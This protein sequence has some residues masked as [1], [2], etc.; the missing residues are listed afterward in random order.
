MKDKNH[1]KWNKERDGT[2]MSKLRRNFYFNAT[3]Y[4]FVLGF[5]M[6]LQH[7]PY[8]ISSI[9]KLNQTNMH[10][11]LVDYPCRTKRSV[12]LLLKLW[13]A[14]CS[15]QVWDIKF[16]RPICLWMLGECSLINNLI[17]KHLKMHTEG[18]IQFNARYCLKMY[19][20]FFHS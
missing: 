12:S 10:I 13:A 3:H 18:Y 19:N 8:G 16:A 5:I 14:I 4:K 9:Y 7:K 6:A 2:I 20:I 15:W 11:L 17:F 1:G